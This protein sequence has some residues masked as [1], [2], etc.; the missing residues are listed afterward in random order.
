MSIRDKKQLYHLTELENLDTI[1]K[2]GLLSRN[3]M[4]KRKIRFT[5]VADS[6]IIKFRSENGLNDYVPFHFFAKNP[7]DGA[8]QLAH[9][10]K[11]FVY[12][13]IHRDFAKNNNF[14]IITRHP[15]S[16][17]PFKLYDYQEGIKNIDWDTFD[18]RDY[19]NHECKEICMAEC[20]SSK[21]ISIHN[22]QS[23][24]VK[25]NQTKLKVLELMEN[26]KI[27]ED[28]FFIDIREN[29]FL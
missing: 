11:V 17:Q 22:F 18:L 14:K 4:L 23:I 8:V 3:Q 15:I 24:A 2:Y 27:D 19:N 16:V 28:N 20:I 5:D 29:C 7:F 13:I 25:D 10:N 6:E 12:I 9:K 26:N 1:F 21:T